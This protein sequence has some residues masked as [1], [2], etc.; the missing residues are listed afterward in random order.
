MALYRLSCE[1][2]L[3]L[4]RAE[5]FAFFADAHN[6]HRITPPWLRFTITTRAPITLR[7]GCELDYTMRWLGMPMKWRSRIARYNPPVEF[8]DTQ[9]H[10]PYASWWHRHTFTDSVG[11]TLV[12]DCVD[13]RMPWGLLG[14]AVRGL[15]VARQLQFI[16]EYRQLKIAELILGERA[17][18]ACMTDP[19][20]IRQVDETPTPP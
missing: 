1:M 15:M 2:W 14:Q 12:G 19:V 3:P 20:L 10:G 9:I 7:S 8:E 13:Y 17:D 6:L 11:G 16:F 5:A 4:E 18:E